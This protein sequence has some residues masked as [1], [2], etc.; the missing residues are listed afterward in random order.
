MIWISKADW[1]FHEKYY[2]MFG[3]VIIFHWKKIGKFLIKLDKV[4]VKK[5]KKAK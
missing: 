1:V 4:I 2:Y 3:K 5:D